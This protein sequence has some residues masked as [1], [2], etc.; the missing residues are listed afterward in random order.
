MK[1][2][3]SDKYVEII[4]FPCNYMEKTTFSSK[5]SVASSGGKEQGKGN[6]FYVFLLLEEYLCNC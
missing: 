4:F 5:L 3:F 2:C 1:V 6:D